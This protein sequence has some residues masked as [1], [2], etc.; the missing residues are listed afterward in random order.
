MMF[1]ISRRSR[2]FVRQV[3]VAL[4]LASGCLCEGNVKEKLWG[5]C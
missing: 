2:E 4:E 5:S 1:G 3:H